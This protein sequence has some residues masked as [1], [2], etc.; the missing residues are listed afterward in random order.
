MWDNP[1]HFL[2]LFIIKFAMNKIYGGNLIGI[3]TSD[4]KNKLLSLLKV[5]N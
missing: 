1:Y 2:R 4:T 5:C 3:I